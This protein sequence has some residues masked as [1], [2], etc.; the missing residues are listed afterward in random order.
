MKFECASKGWIFGEG[1]ESRMCVVWILNKKFGREYG[2]D[3]YG[4]LRKGEEMRQLK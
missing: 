3:E 2:V 4:G 1:W